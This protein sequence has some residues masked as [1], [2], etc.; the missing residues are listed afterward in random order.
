MPVTWLLL[1]AFDKALQGKDE[2][3][4]ELVALYEIGRNLENTSIFLLAKLEDTSDGHFQWINTENPWM[5]KVSYNPV[6]TMVC[7]KSVANTF[8]VNSFS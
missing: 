2:L 4:K 6:F 8:L 7:I 1:A 5:S 3:R